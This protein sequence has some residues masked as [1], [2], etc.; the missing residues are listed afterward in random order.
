MPVNTLAAKLARYARLYRHTLPGSNALNE[1]APLRTQ[2]YPIF[3]S[4]LLVLAGGS[5]STQ[6]DIFD[7]VALPVSCPS[8]R[9]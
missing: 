7:S 5:R 3:P 6:E 9:A 4:V 1:P 8:A 2:F